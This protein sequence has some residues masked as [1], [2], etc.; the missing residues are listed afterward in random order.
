MEQDGLSLVIERMA[1]GGDGA[2]GVPRG[3][4]EE[5]VAKLAGRLFDGKPV[6]AG[7]R[8]GVA[9]AANQR[10]RERLAERAHEA[11]LSPGGAA[12]AQAV[13][14]VGGAQL[15]AERALEGGE[16]EQE[17]GRVG[18]AGDGCQ[19][20][21]SLREEVVLDRE[22]SNAGEQRSAGSVRPLGVLGVSSAG[23]GCLATTG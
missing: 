7:V 8:A 14:E 9:G 22:A 20:A 3:P 4:G 16:C 1:G 6:L 2:A 5:T 23:H 15:E 17:A 21:G 19:D 13:V 11:F 10:H 18:T 12:A